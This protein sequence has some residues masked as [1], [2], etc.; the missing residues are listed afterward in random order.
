[1]LDVI[2]PPL[3]MLVHVP[4]GDQAKVGGGQDIE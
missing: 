2:D 1:M 3:A 4:T